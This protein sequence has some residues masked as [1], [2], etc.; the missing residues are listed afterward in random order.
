MSPEPPQRP[1]LPR[2]G[3]ER[4]PVRVRLRLADS[5]L[6]VIDATWGIIRPMQV[7]DGSPHR[8]RAGGH[9]A[10]RPRAGAHRHQTRRGLRLLH[11]SRGAQHPDDETVERISQLEPAQPTI[12]FCNG[13]QCTA[14]PEAID[15]LLTSKYPAA[16]IHDWISLGLPTE[17]ASPPG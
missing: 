3:R 9:G 14:T 7:I 6:V 13:P 11:D 16:A 15:A 10:P 17:A 4:G 12:F 1:E 8:R 2:A 5:G